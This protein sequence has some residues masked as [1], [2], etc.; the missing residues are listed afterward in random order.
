MGWEAEE[1]VAKR[2]DGGS[3]LVRWQTEALEPVNEVVG[4]EQQLQVGDI[5]D[6]ALGGNFAQRQFIAQFPNR[7]LDVGATEVIDPGSPRAQPQ[8]ADE[9]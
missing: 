5:G 2:L 9:N 1:L 7:F 3:D 8:I 4:Q 6:P